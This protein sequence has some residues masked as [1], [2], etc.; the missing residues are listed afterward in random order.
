MNN[1][2]I[3][4][5]HSHIGVDNTWN[6]A[7]KLDEYIEKANKIGVKESLIMPVPMPII[8]VAGNEIIP[9]ML[10]EYEGEYFMLEMVKD[11]KG[12]RL[13]VTKENP[14]KFVNE[15]LYRKIKYNK[16]Q[17]ILLHFIPLIHPVFDN[18]DYLE[19]IA[20]KYNPVAFKLHGY[21]SII[22][23]K[24]VDEEFWKTINRLNIPLIPHTDCDTSNNEQSIDT[25][26]RNE[27]SPLNWIKILEKYNLKGYLTHGARLCKQSIKLVNDNPYLV[28]G[29]GPDALLSK[30]KDRMYTNASYLD[31]LFSK[32][33]I[34]KI[35]F[36]I[37]YPWNVLSYDCNE[38]EWKQI[39]RLKKLRLK[40]ELEKVLYKN[41]KRFF[42]L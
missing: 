26:Y 39:E 23:P 13:S 28:I 25:Y 29:L 5:A 20:N 37:D 6:V 31:T 14:Y 4:D 12:L 42:K 32:V 1:H 38:L 21:S 30:T 19:E 27:N 33:D 18:I 10:G 34:D 3:I 35:C 41:S 2:R 16:N 15:I 22:S 40:E 11:R 7:G 9:V 8:N 17:D 24:E 36:D